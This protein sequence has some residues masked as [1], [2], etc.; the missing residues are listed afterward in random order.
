M[1]CYA[2]FFMVGAIETAFPGT[3][4]LVGLVD[5]AVGKALA[6]RFDIAIAKC[7]SNHGST[8]HGPNGP[9]DEVPGG[10]AG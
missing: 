3:K 8:N 9:P 7:H 5:K 2:L 10:N 1:R 6:G 4:Y